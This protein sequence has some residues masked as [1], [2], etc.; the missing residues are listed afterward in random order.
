M[1]YGETQN[2]DFKIYGVLDYSLNP[3]ERGLDFKYTFRGVTLDESIK[4]VDHFHINYDFKSTLTYGD[5]IV[6]NVR[7]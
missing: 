3:D 6:P 7:W 4:D 2:N 5:P 1:Q